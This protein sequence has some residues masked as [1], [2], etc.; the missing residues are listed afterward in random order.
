MRAHP[1]SIDRPS[2]VRHPPTCWSATAAPDG[3]GWSS[4]TADDGEAVLALRRSPAEN[5]DRPADDGE[6]VQRLI[7]RDPE[8]LV[9]APSRR[10]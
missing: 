10:P 2:M 5:D 4:T 9:G 1:R 7:E 6:H 3:R 8:A